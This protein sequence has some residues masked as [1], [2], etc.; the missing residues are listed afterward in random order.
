MNAA[1]LEM[2]LGRAA[3]VAGALMVAGFAGLLLGVAGHPYVL[4]LLFAPLAWLALLPYHAQIALVMGTTLFGSALIVPFI[5]GR[6]FIWEAVGFLGWSGVVVTLALREEAAGFRA[7]IARN[8]L[9]FVGSMGFCAVLVF[10]MRK[11]G[12]GFL[13]FG[14]SQ[15]GGRIYFQQ[16]SLGIF[17]LLFAALAPNGKTLLKLYAVQ[18]VLSV[19]MLVADL[20]YTSRSNVGLWILQFVEIP[21]DGWDFE[22]QAM[23]TGLRRF[24]SFFY[25]S[26]SFLGLLWVRYPLKDYFTKRGLWLWPL[27]LLLLG[28]GLFS[29]HRMLIYYL[30][31]SVLVIA[32]AQRIF[33]PVRLMAL[34]LV[35]GTLWI[36]L[37]VA[38]REL[39]LGVQRGI[40][41][42]PFVEIDPMVAANAEA[43]M[44]GRRA[45]KKAGWNVVGN[46]LW[47]GRGFEKYEIDYSRYA[48]MADAWVD[49][50]IFY[51]GTV[52]L[53][54]NTG[55]PGTV[56][57]ALFL[58]G[59]TVCSWRV[60]AHVRRQRAPDALCRLGA[61]LVGGW[62]AYGVSFIFLHGD[63]EF[64]MR[65]FALPAGMLLACEYQLRRQAIAAR[66]T[67]TV[68]PAAT[69]PV[70]ASQRLLFPVVR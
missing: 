25:L 2:K 24:Q 14:G 62:I 23:M 40:S 7:R 12:V 48:D 11:R 50:G 38:S 15:I 65:T 42:I 27:T 17:P 66:T 5:N 34:S 52:G 68:A 47:V 60:C 26:C 6:P 16:I 46:Y 22:N 64:T 58:I 10:I 19:T 59:G 36:T 35:A 61:V 8:L 53:L 21:V 41:A 29:G 20:A 39:P 32:W 70:P 54:V 33:T 28:M 31:V 13:A 3:W 57:I 63:S 9:V 55:V 56:A 18:C 4:I 45:I 30:G 1:E 51:N 69:E 44:E 67:V 37:I 43:T 49:N